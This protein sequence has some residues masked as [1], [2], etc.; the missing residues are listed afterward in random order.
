[1]AVPSAS[2]SGIVN[3]GTNYG[4]TSQVTSTNINAHVDDAVFN[5]NAVDGTTINA[6]SNGKNLFVVD[7]SI[8]V[9]K[10][11]FLGTVDTTA[12]S[13]VKILSKQSDGQYDSV[14]PS[15]D[16]TMSQAGAFT[17]ANNAVTSSKVLQ[18]SIPVSKLASIADQTIVGNNDGSSASP[19]ALTASEVI[20]VLGTNLMNPTS[21]D[22]NTNTITFSNGLILKFGTHTTSGSSSTQTL[23]FS[24]HGGNF[25]NHLYTIQLICTTAISTTNDITINSQSASSVEFKASRAA[26]GDTYSFIALGR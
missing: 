24:D 4:A 7:G 6:D 21:I 14:T 8:S 22:N 13:N 3:K 23:N 10:T 9:A 18:S 11:S 12:D 25:T 15:G 1:M 2:G 17:I 26:N 19:E 16:V 20:G 5:A